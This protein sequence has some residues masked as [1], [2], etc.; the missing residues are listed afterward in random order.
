MPSLRAYVAGEPGMEEARDFFRERFQDQYSGWCD[1]YDRGFDAQ[2]VFF[3]ARDDVTQ[4]IQA[5]CRLHFKCRD[6]RTLPTPM[7]SAVPVGF[8]LPDPPERVCEGGG[9]SYRRKEDLL[10]LVRHMTRWCIR[11]GIKRC[12]TTYDRE[13]TRIRDLYLRDLG[14]SHVEAVVKYGDIRPKNGKELVEWQVAVLHLPEELP[15]DQ[16]DE[17][18]PFPPLDALVPTRQRRRAEPAQPASASS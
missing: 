16:R 7:E 1:G 13:K 6:E 9:L 12:F 2:A 4:V 18:S 10:T 3:V 11:N 15:T 17:N 5:C 8:P 14:F